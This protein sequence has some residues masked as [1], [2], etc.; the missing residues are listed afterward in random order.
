MDITIS[1]NQRKLVKEL[2]QIYPVT[3]K[4]TTELRFWIAGA[5]LS[6]DLFRG[7]VHEDEI[8]AALGFLAHS[9]VLL[10]KYLNVPLRHRIVC[11]SSRSAIQDSDG[12]IL[13]LFLSRVAERPQLERGQV[14]LHRN[15]DCLAQSRGIRGSSNNEDQ[16]QQRQHILVK[17]RDVYDRVIYGS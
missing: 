1:V 15:V 5:E 2:Q 8:S 11:N 16:P 4:Q 3:G 14:L 17:L 10:A 12:K 13:P 7:Q 9:V 6:V